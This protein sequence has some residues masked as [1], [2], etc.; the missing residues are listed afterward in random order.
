MKEKIKILVIPSDRQGVGHYRSIWSSKYLKKYKKEDFDIKID[1]SPDVNNIGYLSSFDIIHFHRQLGGYENS[2]S[3]F[4]KIKETGTKLVMDIDDYWCPPPTHPLHD[5]V[6]KEQIDKKIEKNIKMSDWVTTTTEI[7]ADKIKKLNKNVAVFPNTVEAKSKMW[8]NNEPDKFPK[9]TN[10]VRV[11]WIGGSSHKF[12]LELLRDSMK[13]LSEDLDLREKTQIVMCG[14]DIRGEVTHIMPDGS[15][16]KRAIQPHETVWL[17]FERIFTNNYALINDNEEYKKWLLKIK[18]EEFEDEYEQN[19]V[20]RWTQ[21]LNSY[22]EHYNYCDICLAPLVD[23]YLRQINQGGK[24]KMIQRPHIFNEVKSELKIL[25]AGVKKKAL[26]AQDFGIYSQKLIH[27]KT[28]MLVKNNKDGWYKAI[29]ELVENKNM[30]E[31]LAGNLHEWVIKEYS[32]EKINEIRS[33]FYK[34]IGKK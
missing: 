3:V 13:M 25:E 7:F 9:K 20:R 1:V 22:A 2:K 5:I 10:K 18:K 34:K 26:I 24:I 8:S 31:E 6:K 15:R 19:Y 12:D 16:Q 17:D 23:T 30:R 14:F 32:N 21:N 28:G 29:K 11:G 4:D 27:G 33:D